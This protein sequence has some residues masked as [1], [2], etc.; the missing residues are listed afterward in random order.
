MAEIVYVLTNEAIEGMVKIG[1]TTTSVEHRI[2]ELD[3]ASLPLPFQC[4]YVAEVT[5]VTLVEG[6]LHRI[7]ADKRT[8]PTESYSELIPTKCA[9]PFN[10]Q[11]SR[12]LPNMR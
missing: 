10:S 6:K 12:R 7:F 1:R 9:K 11:N 2:K 5:N 4:F 8:E 3:K